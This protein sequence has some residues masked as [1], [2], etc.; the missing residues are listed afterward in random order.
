[1]KKNPLNNRFLRDLRDDLGKYV[2][3]ALLMIFTIGFVSGFLVADG[4]MVKAY[5]ESFTKYNVEDGNFRLQKKMNKAQWKSVE[6]LGLYLYEL[7]YREFAL[8]NG[9]TLRVFQNRDQV[10]LV[11][12]MEGEF[13]QKPEEIAIDRMY[14]DNNGLK[15]GD[16]IRVMQASAD[17]SAEESAKGKE[18]G[19]SWLITGLVALSD[20]STMFSD[21][22]DTMFDALRFGVAV[23]T[24]EEFA[25]YPEDTLYFNYAW[26]YADPPKTEAEENDRGEELVKDLSKEIRLENYIPRYANQAIRFAGEDMGSDRAMMELLL[27]IMMV[28]IAFVFG[29]TISNTI[30]QE[31]PVIG[32]LRAM[33][34]TKGELVRHYMA[35]PLIVTLLSALVGNILGYT[36]LKNV[37]ADMYYNSYS[38]TKYVTVWNADAFVRTTVFP[39]VIMAVVTWGVLR[40][41][42]GLTPLQF[43]RRQLRRRQMKRAFPLSVRIPF[44]D[45]FRMRVIAQNLPNY[46]IL[47]VGIFF[48]NI[49]LIFGLALPQALDHYQEVVENNLLSKHQ[50]IMQIPLD[51]MD[52]DHKL[53]SAFRMMEFVSETE[54]ENETAE[55]F[56]AYVL[57]TPTDSP[58]HK[59]DVMIYGV[60]AD[61][62]YVKGVPGSG[63]DETASENGSGAG[64][65][66]S[67]EVSG[68]KP[69]PVLISSAYSEKYDV[70]A[71]DRIVLQEKYGEERYN[72]EVAGV[73]DY[74]ASICVFMEQKAL[75]QCFDLGKD[76]FSGY[77]SET[78]I[79]DIDEKYIGSEIDLESLTK[80]TRQLQISM[81][82]MMY[83]VD[84]FAVAIFMVLIYILSKIIIE[85]NAQS[86]SMAKILGYTGSEIGKLYIRSTTVVYLVCFA[87]TIPA[88]TVLIKYLM[89][90][91]IRLEMTGWIELYVGNKVYMQMMALGILS[92]AV[93]AVFEYRKINRVPMDEALKNAE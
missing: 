54:T 31:A 12:L 26:K 9:S 23:V 44:F 64:A 73:F 55:K 30:S 51:A 84:F 67:S 69:I 7:F 1:M 93:V 37:C 92:Y 2:V 70:F 52:E 75:N 8:D 88:V 72:F 19:K 87:A 63:I 41:S 65:Q 34:F 50:Y 85:K 82:S 22:N 5:N 39:I 74:Q 59:E 32:T 15:V 80:V 27:Y 13:P 20:Y 76:Y 49:L 91:M 29:V 14:A 86:I 61:S 38:L 17:V 60:Q 35:M 79:T 36:A 77:F 57:R 66:E 4:S 43:L 46:L 53:V 11:C 24:L 3:I 58:Y 62:R 42:L 89:K 18:A 6:G 68:V 40:W 33:G 21:N 47:L 16:T 45:R 78:P 71:G 81:G 83:L 28:I 48:A 25:Q 10:D 90:I 56:S